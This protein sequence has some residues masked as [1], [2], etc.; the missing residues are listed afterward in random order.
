MS[1][2]RQT[3]RPRLRRTTQ[4]ALVLALL[5]GGCGLD[6]VTI[7]DPAGPSELGT[8]LKITVS[9]DVL[10]A[11]GFST[12][13]VQIQAFDQNGGALGGRAVLLSIIESGG[14]FVDLGTL[15]ATNGSLLRA[16]EATVVTNGSGVAT[17]VYTSPARTDFTADGFITIGA[18]PVGNDATGIAYRTAKIELRSAEP[19]LF[20]P[21][22]GAG[23]TCNFVVEAPQGSTTCSGPTTCT[24]K[25]NTSV[26]FQDTSFDTDGIIVRYDWYWGDGSPNEDSPDSNHVFRTVGDF[27]VTHRVT[28]NTGLASACTAKISVQ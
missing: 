3:P 28:D 22:S 9:P 10:T 7:P 13:L 18:R 21:G 26:L 12:S 14:N 1:M 20:P 19:K 5:A 27:D 11:D 15:N 17:A 25:V 24:V 8:A 23:P 2:Q 4:A 6:E 16:A